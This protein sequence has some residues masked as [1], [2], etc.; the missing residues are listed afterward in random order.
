MHNLHIN[1]FF[2]LF[3]LV[4]GSLLVPFTSNAQ[5]TNTIPY[6]KGD[7]VTVSI[8]ALEGI[9]GLTTAFGHSQ[10]RV[11]NHTK[12]TDNL[13]D[14]AGRVNWDVLTY[15]SEFFFGDLYYDIFTFSTSRYVFRKDRTVDE[16][17]LKLSHEQK[18]KLMNTL[19][20]GYFLQ[21]NARYHYDYLHRN[22]T[23]LM[24]DVLEDVYPNMTYPDLGADKTFRQ[25]YEEGLVYNPW[26]KFFSDIILGPYNDRIA[27]PREQM[28]NP[29]VFYKYLTGAKSN[30]E[31]IGYKQRV[32][33]QGS[34][35]PPL[36]FFQ[37]PG[38][39]VWL[40]LFLEVVLTLLWY[41]GKVNR[42]IIVIYDRLWFFLAAMFAVLIIALWTVSNYDYAARDNWNLLWLS[43][44]YVF[45]LFMPLRKSFRPTK[46]L[47]SLILIS[48]LAAIL[49][50][51]FIP[52]T[53]NIHFLPIM[54]LLMVKVGKYLLS[55]KPAA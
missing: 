34:A 15:L 52:Q 28:F 33:M 24:R 27:T 21:D 32:L 40:L 7:S 1:R 18:E 9:P 6:D 38:L 37:K 35:R 47:L 54:L 50:W 2:F 41:F 23:I 8:L 49:G 31:L 22:C 46:I 29:V 12:N 19:S 53:Y 11:V 36:T 5:H 26:I 30:G 20:G 55:P 44:L 48:T 14:F 25:I 10:F 51:N 45:L 16:L 17:F 42:V 39:Y 13:I 43:P 3:I 4:F